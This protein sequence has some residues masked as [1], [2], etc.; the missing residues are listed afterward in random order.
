MSHLERERLHEPENCCD[1]NAHANGYEFHL[2]VAVGGIDRSGDD[3]CNEHGASLNDH[4]RCCVEL[5][6]SVLSLDFLAP[7]M[8]EVGEQLLSEDPCY[9]CRENADEAAEACH[10]DSQRDVEQGGR[11]V[12]AVEVEWIHDDE[13]HSSR[14]AQNG[15]EQDC[16]SESCPLVVTLVVD[17]LDK[18]VGELGCSVDQAGVADRHYDVEQHVL[19]IP[20]PLLDVRDRRDDDSD[21]D[22]ND[23][24]DWTP[25]RC[26]VGPCRLCH[27]PDVIREQCDE[28]DGSGDAEAEGPGGGFSEEEHHHEDQ[29]GETGRDRRDKEAVEPA[30]ATLQLVL[31]GRVRFLFLLECPADVF[32]LGF[33]GG[34]KGLVALLV[35]LELGL[36]PVDVGAEG[37]EALV[38]G[39]DLRAEAVGLAL[40]GRSAE[41]VLLAFLAGFGEGG[42]ETAYRVFCCLEP[43]SERVPLRLGF[44][45]FALETHD[46]ERSCLRFFRSTVVLFHGSPSFV[47]CGRYCPPFRKR[48]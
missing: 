38:L 15:L 25:P 19:E 48:I 29:P 14:D 9:P 39:P 41:L 32:R 44:L 10:Q 8:R 24:S 26:D 23:S 3:D 20:R 2:D 40:H 42:L 35:L 21:C 28:E 27:L 30:L 4:F 1:H 45:K 18:E 46:V 34:Q 47:F 12:A 6:F 22:R 37:V 33:L 5:I 13:H 43:L 31:D 36:D 16:A 7:E 11:G 17:L